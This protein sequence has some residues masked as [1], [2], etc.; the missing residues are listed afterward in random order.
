MVSVKEKSRFRNVAGVNQRRR[1]FRR[2]KRLGS[3]TRMILKIEAI[4]FIFDY[5][6]LNKFKSV[7]PTKRGNS[8]EK[9][10]NLKNY[11]ANPG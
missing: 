1:F 6:P 10:R 11:P 2:W 5:L 9:G 3:G 4:D 7:E 8:P